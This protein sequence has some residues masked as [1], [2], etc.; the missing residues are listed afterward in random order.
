M[1]TN[2]K[3]RH[4]DKRAKKL[5]NRA[6]TRTEKYPEATEAP[7]M[8]MPCPP[9]MGVISGVGQMMER[10]PSKTE[11]RAKLIAAHVALEAIRHD[12]GDYTEYEAIN[13]TQSSI[14]AAIGRLELRD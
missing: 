11:R 6:A 3:D 5:E 1:N 8:P 2:R 7:P 9:D 10:R 4:M 12:L 13:R 14:A